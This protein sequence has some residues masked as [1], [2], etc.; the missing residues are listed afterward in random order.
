V[1]DLLA[2][3][4]SR[5]SPEAITDIVQSVD[6]LC[7]CLVIRHAW[8][9]SSGELSATCR[10]PVINGGLM[11]GEHPTQALA[12]MYTLRQAFG[13]WASLHVGLVADTLAS[14]EL[15]SLLAAFDAF[16][17]VRVTWFSNGRQPVLPMRVQEQPIETLADH[18]R[19]LSAIYVVPGSLGSNEWS[20]TVASSIRTAVRVNQDLMLLHPLPRGPELPR[21]L[22]SHVRSAYFLQARNGLWVREAVLTALLGRG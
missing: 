10:I 4:D 19:A 9:P 18:A 17:E 3:G 16:P 11:F 15:C 2:A 21:D 22:D 13:T 14:R 7:S 8:S 12:D 1:I 6:L 5:G 20:A